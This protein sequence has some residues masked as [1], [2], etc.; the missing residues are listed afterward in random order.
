MTDKDKQIVV[1]ALWD[2]YHGLN[3]LKQ[4]YEKSHSYVDTSHMEA[5]IDETLRKIIKLTEEEVE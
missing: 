2:R 1:N 3:N 4:L 5:E